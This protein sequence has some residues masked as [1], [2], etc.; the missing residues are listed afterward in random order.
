MRRRQRNA[1]YVEASEAAAEA[2]HARPN[3]PAGFSG[4]RRGIGPRDKVFGPGRLVPLDRN[5]KVRVMMLAR[6]LSRRQE[7]G[8][9]YGQITAKALAVLAAIL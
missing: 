7:P 6:A 8:K 4:S 9:A 5:A 1:R 3:A 2:A